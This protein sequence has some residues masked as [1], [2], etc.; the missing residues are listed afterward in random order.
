MLNEKSGN[1]CRNPGISGP[2]EVDCPIAWFPPTAGA[3][4]SILAPRRSRD[5]VAIMAKSGTDSTE[6]VI[7]YVRDLIARGDLHPGDRLPAERDLSVRLGVS[8]P[9]IRAGLRALAAMGVVKSRHGSGTF[10]PD[11]PPV[12]GSE[13]LRFL[14]ALHGLSR[15][16][17]YE[18]RRVL[19]VGAAGLSA[20]R[21]SAEHVAGIAEE[22][23]SLFASIDDPQEFLVHDIRFHR[24]VASACGNQIIASLVE[25]VSALYYEQRRE[26]AARATNHNLRDAADLHRA[27]YQAIRKHEVDQAQTLM[28]RHLLHSA[29][30][31]AQEDQPLSLQASRVPKA[32][33]KRR[34]AAASASP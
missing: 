14:A 15:E 13:P 8:R 4:G 31:Q 27:I 20:K 29:A 26:T 1:S 5:Q 17:M 2:I 34:R 28:H 7:T 22:V 12:L 24:A 23:A 18:A 10:I 6:Q 30:Y 11:G 19:E 3:I 33:R 16:E 21:A 25:M 9:T 32:G